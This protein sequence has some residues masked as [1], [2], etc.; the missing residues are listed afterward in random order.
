MT[1]AARL[2]DFLGLRRS[3]VGVLLLVVLVGMGERV[4]ERFLPIYLL[5]L[6]GGAVSVGLLQALTNLLGAVYS[7]VGGYL[8][9]RWG[10]RRS[11]LLFNLAAVFGFLIVVLVPAWPAVILG[12]L[13]FL[14]WSAVSLPAMMNLIALALP[15]TKRTM[16]VSL[17]SLV[18]RIPMTLGPLLGG[19]C[20]AAWGERGGVRAAFMVAIG[21]ALVAVFTQQLLI[22]EPSR[23]TPRSPSL[24]LAAARPLTLL[25]QMRPAL[26]A[27]LV[28]DILIRFCEQIPYAFVVVWC[29]KVIEQPVSAFQFG[30]LTAIEMG[31]AVLVYIPVAHHADRLGK[32]PFVI[33]TFVFFTLFPLALLFCRSFWPLVGAFVL[34]GLKEFGEPTRKALIVDLCPDNQRATMFGFYYLV[35]DLVVSLAALGGAFLWQESP[36]VNLVSACAFGVAG[37][38]WFARQAPDSTEERKVSG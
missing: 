30:V 3:I 14:L 20:I 33:V 18:R 37:T 9:D 8:A 2:I 21:A 31:T 11:L 6:G 4:G 15:S 23:P 34:R 16:G 36:A 24:T 25:R 5:A 17:H 26:R 19:L 22:R 27:L 1:W 13:F 28:S 29:M 12:S 32:R 10:I 35:R 7:F 38:V